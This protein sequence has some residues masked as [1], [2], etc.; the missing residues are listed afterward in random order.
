MPRRE[1]L[2]GLGLASGM[3]VA[4]TLAGG[5]ATRAAEQPKGPAGEKRKTFLAVGAH[6]DDAEIG[7][8]G[9]LIHAARAGHRVV[10]VNVV[11]DHKSWLPTVGRE[12]QVRRDLIAL[13]QRFGF[14]KRFL[15]YPYHQIDGGDL[16]LKRKLAEIYVELQPDVAFIHHVE[17]HWPDHVACGRASHDAFLFAHGLSK[18]TMTAQPGVCPHG[19]GHLEGARHP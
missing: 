15:E 3:A 9:V 6:M 19:R 12:Q 2:K 17:D 16:D 10:I 7:A 11:S 14:E 4:G 18:A 8:G 1:M 5:K 13:A